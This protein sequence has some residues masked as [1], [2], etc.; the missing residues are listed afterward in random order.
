MPNYDVIVH[1][2]IKLEVVNPEDVPIAKL[3]HRLGHTTVKKINKGKCFAVNLDG[4]SEQTVRDA[5]DVMCKEALV[6]HVT[7]YHTITS[8]TERKHT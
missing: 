8:V 6:N 4:T 1:V 2:F 7:E 5:V 3:L